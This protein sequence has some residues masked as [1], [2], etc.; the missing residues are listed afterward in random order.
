HRGEAVLK[1]AGER[2]HCRV[3]HVRHLLDVG[4]GGEH[5]LSPVDDVGG[6]RRVFA[7]LGGGFR[8]FPLDLGVE[9]VHLRPVQPEDGDGWM[10]RIR[11]DPKKLTH[12]FSLSTS[13]CGLLSV[14]LPITPPCPA[15][16]APRPCRFPSG[17]FSA[18]TS[19][20][21]LRCPKKDHLGHGGLL[22]RAGPGQN[23]RHRR[24]P[25]SVTPGHPCLCQVNSS[26]SV[27]SWAETV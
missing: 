10:S 6:D 27:P 23:A 19:T 16:A 15:W 17:R 14:P 12:G 1:G 4:S 2:G 24:M 13:R 3:V 26:R 20:L 9:R 5:A 25:W 18:G 11:F 8:E 22:P 7:D 21:A